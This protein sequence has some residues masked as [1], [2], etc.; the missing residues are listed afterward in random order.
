MNDAIIDLQRTNSSRSN[1]YRTRGF[2]GGEVLVPLEVDDASDP[3]L[4]LTSDSA[5]RD[6]Y[7]ENG[8]VVVRNV[9][10]K[11]L[12]RI[13]MRTFEAQ[14]KGFKGH[15][16]RQPSSGKAETHKFTPSGYVENSIL[17]VHDLRSSQFGAFKSNSLQVLTHENLQRAL[18]VFLGEPG[19]LVQ[20]M[21]FEGNPSTWP[22][23]DTYYLDSEHIGSLV[24]AWVAV[25]DIRPGA[26]RF[27]VY[28][29]SH[30]IDIKKNGG[31]FDIAFNHERYKNLT[32]SVIDRN[33]LKLHAPALRQGDV[34][35]WNSKTIHGSLPT[36]QSEYSRSS[37]TGHYIPESHRFLQ[38]QSRIK[39]FRNQ[40]V[41]KMRVN[42]PKDQDQLGNRLMFGLETKFPR[43]F[44]ALKSVA[45]KI[46]TH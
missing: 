16:Y 34:L 7:L 26:G 9:I 42:H 23:Q 17:N 44:Q 10:P 31:D 2:N 40:I 14:L 27:Y 41:N 6:Y 1:L 29:G 11:E 38:F 36:T 4:K 32:V 3:Y 19:A 28:P 35:F 21:Y 12:C 20:S 25:E 37:F 13:A 5:I 46:V 15:L 18:K 43:A 24:A 30:K 45:I 39:K 8:Y 22:H 33:N